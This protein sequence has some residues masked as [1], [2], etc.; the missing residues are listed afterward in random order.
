[1]NMEEKIINDLKGKEIPNR[2]ATSVMIL[3]AFS[4]LTRMHKVSKLYEEDNK[5]HKSRAKSRKKKRRNRKKHL[6]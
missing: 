5:N 4:E 1:M 6:T 2:T 3:R